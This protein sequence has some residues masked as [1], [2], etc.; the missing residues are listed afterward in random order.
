M[1]GTSS[2]TGIGAVGAAYFAISGAGSTTAG[3]VQVIGG[4]SGHT[5]EADR[6]AKFLAS[7]TTVSGFLAF[8]SSKGNVE[9]A[10]Q[11]AALEGVFTTNPRDLFEGK[12]SQ[13]FAKIADF[14]QNL[15]DAM[16]WA[17]IP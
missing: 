6:G 3:I 5:K 2:E 12:M 7:V 10:S 1:A 4:V 9:K 8:P 14:A 17:P 15:K 11:A 13:I 16:T